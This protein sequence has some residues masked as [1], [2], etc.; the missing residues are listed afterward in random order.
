[1]APPLIELSGITKS[2]GPVKSLQGV[3]LR[4]AK[5]EVLGVVGD[6]GAGKST[7]MKILA[8]AVQHDGGEMRVNG[9][10]VRFSTPLDAQQKKIGIVYQDLALCDTLDVASNLFLGREPRKG[11]FLDRHAMHEKAAHI[12][13]DLHVKVK[14]TYQEIGQLSGG[15][16]ANRRDRPRSLL[17]PRRTDPRR[18]HRSA[19]RRRGRVGAQADHGRRSGRRGRHSRDTPPAGPVPRV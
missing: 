4:L 19:S 15:P 7:L 10:P 6:N 8:G 5:G 12:L 1:M 2:Y 13:A 9:E 16:A 17:P 11:P 18:A 14:S 3:D